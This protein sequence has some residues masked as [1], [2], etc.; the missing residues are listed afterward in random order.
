MPPF[1]SCPQSN[2][3]PITWTGS[4]RGRAAEGGRGS[5]TRH[6]ELQHPFGR[7]YNLSPLCSQ[8]QSPSLFPLR[9]RGG[10]CFQRSLC[11]SESS[12]GHA[13]GRT[14]HVREAD[15]MAE[16]HGVRIATV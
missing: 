15:P 13:E 4:V 3:V 1:N 5:L 10:H 9:F 8:V 7:V 2:M 14:A 6:L 11:G 16:L 12:Y